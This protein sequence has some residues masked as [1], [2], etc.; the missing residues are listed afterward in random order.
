VPSLKPE[1]CCTRT[2]RCA[3][4]PGC[5]PLLRSGTIAIDEFITSV[6][7]RKFTRLRSQ[8]VQAMQVG[9]QPINA[10]NAPTAGRAAAQCQCNAT[11]GGPSHWR[12]HR[13]WRVCLFVC[14]FVCFR[15]PVPRV[16]GS[17]PRFCG[18]RERG[19]GRRSSHRCCGRRRRWAYIHHAQAV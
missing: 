3:L 1:V 10:T 16:P 17:G 19:L 5:A 12:I 9:N 18:H 7:E 2:L 4:T 14:L 13:E 11:L 8:F 15:R 6:W